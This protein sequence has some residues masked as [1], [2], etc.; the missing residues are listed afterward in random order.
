MRGAVGQMLGFVD[1]DTIQLPPGASRSMVRANVELQ[2]L[3]KELS[4]GDPASYKARIDAVDAQAVRGAA[5][6]HLDPGPRRRSSASAGGDRSGS[7]EEPSFVQTWTRPSSAR[8][9]ADESPRYRDPPRW[10]GR[11]RRSATTSM[12]A[13]CRSRTS[14][15]SRSLLGLVAW[16]VRRGRS[17]AGAAWGDAARVA[18]LDEEIIDSSS[19]N[20]PR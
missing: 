16:P 8:H 12:A 6:R 14:D 3:V 13:A 7:S 5:A 20:R 11:S 15:Q 9:T 19:R 4:W 10:P 2:R 17:P 1:V 18:E